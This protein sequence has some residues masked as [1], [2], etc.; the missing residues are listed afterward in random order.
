MHFGPVPHDA[1]YSKLKGN[2]THDEYDKFV[3]HLDARGCKTMMDWLKV[4]NKADEILFIEAVDKTHKQ[5]YPDEIDMFKD[6]VSIPGISTMYVLN[7]SLR[8]KQPGEPPLF[9]P[10]QPCF[11][12]CTKY[13]VDPKPG[14]EK[15]KKVR[16]GCMQCAKTSHM[17]F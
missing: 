16:N 3:R 11:H 2:I 4:Y 17:N 9:A 12:K 7:K 15:C 14:R 6:E 8:M 5:Y 13:E 10:G 1:F